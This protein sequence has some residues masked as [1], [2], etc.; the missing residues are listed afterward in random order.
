MTENQFEIL[1]NHLKDIKNSVESLKGDPSDK[2]KYSLSDLYSELC[3]IT[4]AVDSL[5]SK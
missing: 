4:S 3:S 1:L 5:K 2:H